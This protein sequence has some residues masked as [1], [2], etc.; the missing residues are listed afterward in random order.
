MAFMKVCLRPGCPTLIQSGKGAYC[1]EHRKQTTRSYNQY[2]RDPSVQQLYNSSKW[3]S[4][5][6][7]HKRAFPLCQACLRAEPE[8]TTAGVLVDHVI[9]YKP[10]DN[11]FDWDNLE[12]LCTNCHNVKHKRGKAV[13]AAWL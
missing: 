9:E 7:Q 12:T 6:D 10:G 5:R 1:E 8:R 13:K 3:K 2:G 11:F 4:V